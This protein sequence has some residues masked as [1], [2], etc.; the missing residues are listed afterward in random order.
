MTWGCVRH[1][2]GVGIS[3][4]ILWLPLLSIGM[5][6]YLVTRG[7]LSNPNPQAKGETENGIT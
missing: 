4:P 6:I 7:E 2:F 3:T 5:I 1:I